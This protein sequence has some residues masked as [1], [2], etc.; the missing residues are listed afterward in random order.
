[1][2]KM[3]CIVMVCI[4]LSSLP[5]TVY[6][7]NT[8]SVAHI[9]GNPGEL[10]YLSVELNDAVE[11]DTVGIQYSYDKTLLD[12]RPKHSRWEVTGSIRDFSK[13]KPQG[14]WSNSAPVKLQGTLC[15]LA[16]RIKENAV[17]LNTEVTC[18]VTIK[19]AGQEV[20]TYTADGMISTECTHRFGSWSSVL[21]KANLKQTGFNRDISNIDLFREI[22]RIWIMLGK[23]PTTDDMKKGISK[24]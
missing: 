15:V 23:Q 17:F 16:F 6:A 8:L 18:T 5:L 22:E 1:M 2:K 7:A 9:N 21:E 11:G 20:A 24:F 4:L 19:N 3:I 10:V 12:A 13:A 14:A